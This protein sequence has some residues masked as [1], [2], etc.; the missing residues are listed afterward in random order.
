M[1]YWSDTASHGWVYCRQ[2]RKWRSKFLTHTHSLTSKLHIHTY[3]QCIPARGVRI[4]LIIPLSV[5]TVVA[6][7]WVNPIPWYYIR[8]P[9]D[10]C[11]SSTWFLMAHQWVL[12]QAYPTPY[13]C[14]Y[15][16]QT[17]CIQSTNTLTQTKQA[18][19]SLHRTIP[20]TMQTQAWVIQTRFLVRAKSS[21]L[22]V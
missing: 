17:V 20:C 16:R 2:S 8:V 15:Y 10:S 22:V 4:L 11:W 13:C 12:H 18:E 7:T 9:F 5:S 6:S 14:F 1:L 19:E 3:S 21:T